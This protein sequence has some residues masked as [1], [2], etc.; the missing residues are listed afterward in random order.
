MAMKRYKHA[1]H[2]CADL[3]LA[4]CT[5][6]KCCLPV[7]VPDG[8]SQRPSSCTAVKCN[9]R[10]PLL[11]EVAYASDTCLS[12]DRLGA[13]V[14]TESHLQQPM[15]LP[16]ATMYH[17]KFYYW[18]ALKPVDCKKKHA[19]QDV[20]LAK[21]ARAVSGETLAPDMCC[22]NRL[23]HSLSVEPAARHSF[24]TSVLRIAIT[25]GTSSTLWCSVLL[26][27]CLWRQPS[28]VFGIQAHPDSVE[29]SQAICAG[30]DVRAW[31]SHKASVDG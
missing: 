18:I 25:I 17:T 2:F 3:G 29:P 28:R 5:F 27:I 22:Q 21:H 20:L 6:L 26:C 30:G 13:D 8:P 10:F 15:A 11:L 4:H 7:D 12:Q 9:V 24:T 31:S 1:S 14:H 23:P 16:A 19:D